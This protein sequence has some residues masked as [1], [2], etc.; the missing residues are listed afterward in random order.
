M[1]VYSR[2]SKQPLVEHLSG[3][4]NSWEMLGTNLS[5]KA[6]DGKWHSDTNRLLLMDRKEFN[7]Q[8]LGLDDLIEAYIQTVLSIIAIDKMAI[9]LMNSKGRFRKKLFASL[10][11]DDSF[12]K[13]ILL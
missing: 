12:L 8:G 10:N 13:E 5:F 9:N 2:R 3:S 11:R 7:L 4:E 1:V 6:K